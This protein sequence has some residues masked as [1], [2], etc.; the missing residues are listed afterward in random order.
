MKVPTRSPSGDPASGLAGF[1]SIRHRRPFQASLLAWYRENA[2]PLRIRS[3]RQPW[4]VLVAEVMAQQTQIARVDD[5]WA[6]FLERFPTPRALAEASPADVLRAWSGLG[7]NRRAV[8]LQRAAGVIVAAHDGR[9]PGGVEQ[10][11]ELPGVG[12]YTA[13]A[14]AALAFAQPV[15]AVDT[16][17]RRVISRLAGQVLSARQLQA[18]ADQL[19]P[20]HDPATWTHASMELGATLCRSRDPACD[21]CPVSRWCASAGRHGGVGARARVAQNSEMPPRRPAPGSGMP[22]R[23]PGPGGPAFEHTTRWLRGRIVAQLRALEDG[24]WTRLP[25]TI[26]A[27][28]P[29]QVAAA[30][31]ALQLD[32]LLELRADGSVRLPSLLP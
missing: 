31:A 4:P 28:G 9:V 22:P 18:A 19:V 30:T 15:A 3:T 25:D 8:N 10:L 1:L 6:G 26:G 16:N 17:V 20:V 12:P 21:V 11:E 23:P 29:D 32:G 13:R 14:V 5:A 27:H 2:R 24:A 7:Y